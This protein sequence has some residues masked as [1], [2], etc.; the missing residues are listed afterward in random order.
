MAYSNSIPG[1]N[2]LLSQ[3]QQDIQDNFAAIKTLVDINHVTFDTGDQGK[4]KHIS[5]PEQG[6]DPTTAANEK[7]L[8][9]KQSALSGVAELFIRNES[10]GDVVEITSAT[11]A[12]EGW[13]MLPSGIQLVWG[14]STIA[15]EIQ[16]RTHTFVQ[17][18]SNSC[19]QVIICLGA[20]GN[21]NVGDYVLGA[22]SMT[23]TTFSATR[24]TS[25]LKGTAATYRFLA[26]GY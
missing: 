14:G 7:A 9:S 22:T 25:A 1:A 8:Y 2:D 13:T 24:A 18:F 3:S 4:H 16:A 20:T 11:K 6:A 26:I 21:G 15:G 17:P 19:L 12:S 10:D 23:T 5:F